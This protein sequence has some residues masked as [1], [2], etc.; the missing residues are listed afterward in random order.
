MRDW[1][2]NSA[3]RKKRQIDTIKYRA[4]REDPSAARE[5]PETEK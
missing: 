2:I 4:I 5:P 3:S 1:A